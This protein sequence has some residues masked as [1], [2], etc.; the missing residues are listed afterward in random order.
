VRPRI[1]VFGL[2]KNRRSALAQVR[3]IA[4]G[5][6]RS[7][8][9]SGEIEIVV[10]DSALMRRLNA[11][12]RGTHRPTD[13]LS[14]SYPDGAPRGQVF[15]SREAVKNPDGL[16]RLLVH[17]IVHLGGYEHRTPAQRRRMEKKEK[18]ILH[19]SLHFRT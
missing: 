6:A 15:V 5:A 3:R 7:L 12:Y 11:A 14:F 17:A 2:P 13:V 8:G 19:E 10:A 9:L 4:C 18:E 1:N 16:T